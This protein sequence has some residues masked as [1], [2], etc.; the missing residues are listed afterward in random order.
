MKSPI[1][2]LILSL[3]SFNTHAQ[4]SLELN[5]SVGGTFVDIDGIIEEDEIQGTFA[6]DWNTF[7]YGFGGQFVF[8]SVSNI[9][10]GTEIM[11]QYLYWYSVSVPFG[12]QRIYRVYDV[13]CTR[14]TPFIRIGSNSMFSLDL[15]PELNFVDEMTL[16]FLISGNLYIPLSEKVAIPIKLRADI[17][18]N[19]GMLYPLS[20]NTGL[21]INL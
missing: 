13:S 18:N 1:I 20:L 10:F 15:G 2:L 17:V 14:I 4:G 9:G 7:N 16:G 11:Y 6:T 5:L 8:A 21:R 12:S 3:I 19:V